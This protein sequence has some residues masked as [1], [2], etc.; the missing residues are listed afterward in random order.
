MSGWR[1]LADDELAARLTQR[2]LQDSSVAELVE[3][4][5]EDEHAELID[6]MLT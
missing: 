3:H 5:D 6:R 1:D 2:G 4:R